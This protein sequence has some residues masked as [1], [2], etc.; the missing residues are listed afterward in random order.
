MWDV[1]AD[2]S[3]NFYFSDSGTNRI[4]KVSASGILSTYAG[5]GGLATSARLNAPHGVGVDAAGN[6]YIADTTNYRI[7]KIN[8]AG[9]ISTVAGNGEVIT[10]LPSGT[11]RGNGDGSAATAANVVPWD[12]KPDS[13]GN[14]Y[15]SDWLN[16]RIRKVDGSGIITTIAGNG[17]VGST[18]DGGLGTNALINNPTG[19]AVDAGGNVYFAEFQGNRIRKVNAPPLGPPTI[20]TTN[21]VVP[22]FMGNAGFSSNMYVEIYGTNFSNVSRVWAG[23]DFSGANAPTS[24]EGVSV[25]INGK[26]AYVYYVSP[27]QINV[28][29]PEDT[30]TGSVSIQ[31]ITSAGTSNTI[32]AQRSRLSPAMLT[33]PAFNIGGKQFVAALTPN[34]ASFIGRPNMIAGVSFV[35]P[36][37][38]DTVSIYA[39]GAGPT[40][41]PTQAGV[42]ASQ[43]AVLASPY[44]VKIGGVP[45]TVSFAGLLAGTIGLYQL[46]VV[47]PPVGAADQTIEFIVDGVSNNQSLYIT[48]GP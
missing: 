44:Q 35:T 27:G 9:I 36:R 16:H 42:T 6:I 32:N 17:T 11:I 39:L 30:A 21:T 19:V 45:A 18:G 1:V 43:N 2:K 8:P 12:V 29:V 23:S 31:V 34:F 10:V 41:P 20:R 37:P 48:V 15:I 25:R 22:A 38:G 47:I 7:R 26:L 40:N 24:L 28:N 4:R 33:T 14:L 5:D 3:G 13:N 46:N